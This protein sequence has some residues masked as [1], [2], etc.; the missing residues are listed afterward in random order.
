MA[1]LIGTVIEKTVGFRATKEVE[2]DG[3]DVAEHAE[4][5]YEFAP[6]GGGGGGFALAGVRCTKGGR[7]RSGRGSRYP[8][9][10]PVNVF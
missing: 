7:A 9:R 6:T 1:Y 5:A 2:V 10:S 8:R 3:I 4:S